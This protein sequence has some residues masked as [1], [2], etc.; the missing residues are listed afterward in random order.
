V[1]A[2]VVQ[3][4]LG[5]E[6]LKTRVAGAWHFYNSIDGSRWDLTL[7]QFATPIG[8]RNVWTSVLAQDPGIARVAY[9]TAEGL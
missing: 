7:S 2:L 4:V 9:E 5:G 6:I 1:T 8:R 3:D